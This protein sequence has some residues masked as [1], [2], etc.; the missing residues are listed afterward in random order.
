MLCCSYQGTCFRM[1]RT[2][3]DRDAVRS[4]SDEEDVVS[5]FCDLPKTSLRG[6]S[7]P[8]LKNSPVSLT[9]DYTE[10]NSNSTFEETVLQPEKQRTWS[11]R[12]DRSY[13]KKRSF[14]EISMSKSWA[15]DYDSA[16]PQSILDLCDEHECR[17]CGVQITSFIIRRDHYTGAKH[18][19]KVKQELEEICQ[20]N[21]GLSVPKKLKLEP[22]IDTLNCAENFLKKI[23]V[24]QVDSALTMGDVQMSVLHEEMSSDWNQ[25]LPPGILV[26]CKATKCD[27]CDYSCKNLSEAR[28]HYRGKNHEKKFKICLEAFCQQNGIPVPRKSINSFTEEDL[29]ETKCAL[30]NVELS[31]KIMAKSHYEGKPHAKKKKAAEM[32][33]S[34][35]DDVDETGRFGIGARFY[36]NDVQKPNGSDD[37]EENLLKEGDIEEGMDGTWGAC[38]IPQ[39]TSK[40]QPTG[41][42]FYLESN[43]ITNSASS[44]NLFCDICNLQS[45]SQVSHN[46]HM[47]GKNH[48]KKVNLLN[49]SKSKFFC[50]L[51]NITTTDQ[52]TLDTH[53]VGKSH[54]SKERRLNY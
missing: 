18:Q 8:K 26:L 30:C 5:K 19:K 46:A 31:S 25:D 7:I 43:S 52:G 37:Q 41:A 2:Y 39:T 21:E 6:F 48:K 17:L 13:K 40:S 3:I 27:V 12:A 34:K 15:Q 29:N 10:E 42:G 44:G 33:N 1:T 45:T 36:K 51:C 14:Q 35:S 22:K 4:S 47:Q 9:T 23:D 49:S 50:E 28:Q 53:L 11:K 24:P 38:E 16:I 54:K 20:A 32:Q